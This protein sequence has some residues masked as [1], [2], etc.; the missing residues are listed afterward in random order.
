MISELSREME[1]KE[2]RKEHFTV[3]SFP[4]PKKPAVVEL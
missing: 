1:N 3:V 2:V 4:R